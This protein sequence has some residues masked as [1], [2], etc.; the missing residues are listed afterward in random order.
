MVSVGIFSTPPGRFVMRST[1]RLR[2]RLRP[3][4]SGLRGKGGGTEFQT[5]TARSTNGA[6]ARIALTPSP[7]AAAVA[8]TIIRLTPADW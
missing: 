6:M 2:S 1:K 5:L 8:I 4:P 3:S 7:D